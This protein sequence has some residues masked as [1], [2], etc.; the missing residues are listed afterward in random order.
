MNPRMGL[1]VLPLLLAV[2]PA[3]GQTGAALSKTRKLGTAVHYRNLT[4]FPVYDSAARSEDR[5]LTMDEGLK[6]RGLNVR[7]K[8]GGGEVNTVFVTNTGRKPVYLM[9]G[10][11]IL[12]GQQDRVIGDDTIV[13]P[14]AKNVPVQVYCVE[15]GRW[16]GRHEFDQTAAALAVPSVRNTAQEGAF[17][18]K[19]ADS[20]AF[21]ASGGRVARV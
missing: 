13:P 17:M 21:L 16:S 6:S 19:V 1:L 11:V 8:Q 15:H 12:G 10:E 14:Q 3:T 20:P 18:A 4:L 2:L 5:F 7:E 9:S